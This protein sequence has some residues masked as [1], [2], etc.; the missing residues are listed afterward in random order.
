MRCAVVYFRRYSNP[1]LISA[2]G[3]KTIFPFSVEKQL[4]LL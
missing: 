3:V 2:G 4:P 1:T